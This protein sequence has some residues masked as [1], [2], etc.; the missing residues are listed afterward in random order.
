M[1]VHPDF[2]GIVNHMQNCYNTYGAHCQSLQLENNTFLVHGESS[3]DQLISLFS[4]INR[5]GQVQNWMPDATILV[6][7]PLM[8]PNNIQLIYGLAIEKLDHPRFAKKKVPLF[9]L[10]KSFTNLKHL[11]NFFQYVMQFSTS[12]NIKFREITC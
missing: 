3:V 9:V 10:G 6:E 11:F 8:I 2:A 5:T 1:L 12:T 7:N 4:H